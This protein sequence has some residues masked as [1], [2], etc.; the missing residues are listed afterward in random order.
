MRFD[1]H[2]H[3]KYSYDSLMSPEIIIKIARKKGLN[4]VAIT[5]HNTILGGIK[6]SKVERAPDF[7]I[8][9]GTEIKTELGDIL[10][11]FL[12]QE[13][14]NRIFEDVVEEIKTQGG[15]VV[16]PHPYRGHKNLE[17]LIEKA[18]L[19]EGFNARSGR[20]DNEM[21]LKMATI[22]NKPLTAGSDAHSLFEVGRGVTIAGEN[23]ERELKNGRTS[24]QGWESN[25]YLSHGL[26]LVSEKLRAWV[27]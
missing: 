27:L 6:A 1:L 23:L 19:I 12:N 26:S 10:G 13:I 18:D 16:L 5:D 24:I 4:G 15:L 17:K 22:M 21:S 7:Q 20:K 11:L 25:Y 9:I 8:I 14:K 2:I 3:S